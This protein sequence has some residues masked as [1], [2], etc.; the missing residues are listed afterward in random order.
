[1]QCFALA[2][3]AVNSQKGRNS[4]RTPKRVVAV[5]P[6]IGYVSAWSAGGPNFRL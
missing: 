2:R 3:L 5:L 6:A 1:M 4:T